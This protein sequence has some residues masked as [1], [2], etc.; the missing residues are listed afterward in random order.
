MRPRLPRRFTPRNAIINMLLLTVINPQPLHF[1]FDSSLFTLT[2][3]L[4]LG[5][6]LRGGAELAFYGKKAR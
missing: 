1:T 6:G 3:L 5:G 4:L 2:F